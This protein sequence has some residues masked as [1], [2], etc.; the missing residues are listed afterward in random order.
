MGEIFRWDVRSQGV[1]FSIFMTHLHAHGYVFPQGYFIL[2]SLYTHEMK[3]YKGNKVKT[4][5]Y[6]FKTLHQFSF[7]IFC[8]WCV[9]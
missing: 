3:Y 5:Q 4:F 2:Q 6:F 8:E 7:M 9:N 1:L